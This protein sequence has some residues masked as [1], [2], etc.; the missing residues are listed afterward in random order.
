MPVIDNDRNCITFSFEQKE[1]EKEP[2]TSINPIICFPIIFIIVL[3]VLFVWLAVREEEEVEVE[4]KDE[5]S[6]SGEASESSD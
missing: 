3:L 6:D 5:S 1:P 2:D 4:E